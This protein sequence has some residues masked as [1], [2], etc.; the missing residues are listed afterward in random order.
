MVSGVTFTPLW[1]LSRW[2]LLSCAALSKYTTLFSTIKLL[3]FPPSASPIAYSAVL[4]DLPHTAQFV[5]LH[6]VR[7]HWLRPLHRGAREPALPTLSPLLQ[8][9]HEGPLSPYTTSMTLLSPWRSTKA[10]CA[11]AFSKRP[12]HHHCGE[13]SIWHLS[14]TNETTRLIHL[15]LKSTKLRVCV[16]EQV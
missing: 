15:L 13:V 9:L 4:S 7:T 8:V 14:L 1:P 6:G 11:F 12:T 10:I 5:D 2:Y 3:F 16:G